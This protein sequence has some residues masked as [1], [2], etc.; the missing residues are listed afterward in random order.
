MARSL[1]RMPSGGA[2]VLQAGMVHAAAPWAMTDGSGEGPAAAPRA[3]PVAS[4]PGRLA[5][6]LAGA[7]PDRQLAAR[8]AVE[9][10]QAVYRAELERQMQEKAERRRQVLIDDTALHGLEKGAWGDDTPLLCSEREHWLQL[11]CLPVSTCKGCVC[12]ARDI[13]ASDRSNPPS[14]VR[15][16][17]TYNTAIHTPRNRPAVQEQAAE[18]AAVARKA[19]EAE[20]LR[21]RAAS[22]AYG[23]GSGPLRDSQGRPITDLNQACDH[24]A[25]PRFADKNCLGVVG[26]SMPGRGGRGNCPTAPA[27]APMQVRRWQ[28]AALLAKPDGQPTIHQPSQQ[29]AIPAHWGAAHA[30]APAA[31]GTG[32]H[33]AQAGS[34]LPPL[35][36]R[37]TRMSGWQEAGNSMGLLATQQ[38]QRQPSGHGGWLDP[39]LLQEEG[40]PGLR[41]SLH[42][43]QPSLPPGQ[44]Q[45]EAQLPAHLPPP[46]WLGAPAAP[47]PEQPRGDAMSGVSAPALISSALQ[48]PGAPSL[49][50]VGGE[51]GA[52][53]MRL[54]SDRPFQTA[55]EA[56]RR[57]RAQAELQA[58]LRAQME[59][60]ARRKAEE[61]RRRGPQGW[62]RRR[63]H[64]RV[65]AAE[66]PSCM[67]S[68]AGAVEA[69]MRLV[70]C[71]ILWQGLKSLAAA[72]VPTRPPSPPVSTCLQAAGGG[73]SRGGTL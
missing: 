31:R 13:R 64:G 1:Q 65:A 6:A 24:W 9:R 22:G 46:S 62:C 25:C 59:E 5:A 18:Q 16:L 10:K 4:G 30:E 20:Q 70:A 73:C 29:A 53:R 42:H 69:A 41:H 68:S 39:P 15:S 19:A 66:Q 14:V 49:P 34:T 35:E 58:A 37:P 27:C 8:E 36:R 52:P 47:Q 55:G 32:W 63:L 60:K 67:A 7:G 26:S 44:G 33:D 11:V 57:A 48:P 12:A 72:L 54:R 51:A 71:C 2:A 28:V 45:P 50:S 23:G 40:P 56:E 17:L 3:G 43:A 21:R 61:Q 38:L